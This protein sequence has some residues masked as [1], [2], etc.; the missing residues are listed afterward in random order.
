[1][2]FKIITGT[3]GLLPTSDS[4]QDGVEGRD[5]RKTFTNRRLKSQ[6]SQAQAISTGESQVEFKEGTRIYL[7]TRVRNEAEIPSS[8]SVNL[9][10]EIFLRW[11]G[12]NNSH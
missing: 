11:G 5:N 1:M 12:C 2:F 4:G 8:I 6:V 3:I 10:D 9:E 7:G